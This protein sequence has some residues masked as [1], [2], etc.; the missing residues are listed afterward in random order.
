MP[1]VDTHTR[2][3]ALVVFIELF[4]YRG[5]TRD[6]WEKRNEDALVGGEFASG[7]VR[8]CVPQAIDY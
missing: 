6:V 3:R 7:G 2:G 5:D 8:A 1:F 4:M